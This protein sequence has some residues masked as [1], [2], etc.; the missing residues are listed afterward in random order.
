MKRL[1]FL[2]AL[3]SAPAF[4]QTCPVAA[5]GDTGAVVS[6]T[7]PT[8]GVQGDSLAGVPLTYTV[9]QST[10]NVT[11]TKAQSGLTSLSVAFSGLAYS[12]TYYWKISA[13]DSA[14]EGPQTNAVCKSIAGQ[15]QS[16]PQA[17]GNVS[18]K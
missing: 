17:P 9:Y 8:L 14:G 16:P 5:S 18:V 6:W 11:Y 7:A 3:F 12:T 1:L 10:D 15:P 2:L 4:S 13:T